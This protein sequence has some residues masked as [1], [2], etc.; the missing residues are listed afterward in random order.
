[1]TL[2]EWFK[3]KIPLEGISKTER[4]IE[5]NGIYT[6]CKEA[7]CP[8]K[9]ECFSKKTATFLALGN[10][11]TRSCAF[12][13]VLYSKNPKKLDENEPS[14]IA[15][16]AKKL[17]LKHV[18]ITMVTRDDLEDGGAFQLV[19]IIKE[20]KKQNPSSTI[21]VL[22]SDF[23][24]N[25]NSIDLIL[26]EGVDVFNHNIETTRELS[27]KIRHLANYERSMMILKYIKDQ[28]IAKFVKSGFMV[29][30]GEEKKEVFETITDLKEAN[31]DIITIGQYLQP[32]KTKH[33]VIRYVH[34]DEFKEYISFA[35]SLNIKHI[36][37]SPF[38]RSS[39]NAE[40][41]FQN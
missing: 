18:V 24:G 5:E 16:A 20:V 2:P 7:K 28:N 6:I 31:C 29:G 34:P 21:E 40:I 41:I 1:M 19:R 9:A 3:I 15:S 38:V 36:F 37:A 14:K 8:N 4:T 11:C 12:C 39:Y 26:N 22:T 13:S 33:T 30:L 35:K 27:P 25:L 17:N 32:I 23:A 10:L